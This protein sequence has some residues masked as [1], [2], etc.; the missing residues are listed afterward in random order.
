MQDL[1]KQ[2]PHGM[3]EVANN[4]YFIDDLN[5]ADNVCFIWFLLVDGRFVFQ[6][7]K[8]WGDLRKLINMKM[9]RNKNQSPPFTTL[10]AKKISCLRLQKV[11]AKY[12]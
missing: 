12:A 6:L 10:V 5:M 1:H 2:W 4:I 7:V 8:Y 3:L 9:Q 11:H